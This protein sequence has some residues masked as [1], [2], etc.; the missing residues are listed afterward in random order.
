MKQKLNQHQQGTGHDAHK[1]QRGL[2]RQL[3]VEHNIRKQHCN[4]NT[5]LVDGDDHTG[6]AVLQGLIVA[7]P[8]AA[9][10]KPQR[11]R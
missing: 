2:F 3:F 5:Q 11:G 10:G 7:Q 1:S 4:Q 9:G 8:A 6:R